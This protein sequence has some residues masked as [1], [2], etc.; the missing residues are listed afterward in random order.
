MPLSSLQQEELLFTYGFISTTPQDIGGYRIGLWMKK[1]K[2]VGPCYPYNPFNCGAHHLQLVELQWH[3]RREERYAMNW[4]YLDAN[5]QFPSR[6]RA[7]TT[8][9]L[10]ILKNTIFVKDICNVQHAVLSTLLLLPL[11]PNGKEHE[12][13]GSRV[14]TYVYETLQFQAKEALSAA[15]CQGDTT[16]FATYALSLFS[17]DVAIYRE[18]QFLLKL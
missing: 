7:S 4:V 8:E 15:S 3:L 6:R 13:K 18:L 17:T 16:S 5:V 12:N 9:H 2:T 14:H 11:L 1:W 10:G